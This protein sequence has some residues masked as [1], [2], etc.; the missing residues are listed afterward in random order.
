ME[1]T[2]NTS[3]QAIGL[4]MWHFTSVTTEDDDVSVRVEGA[5]VYL[6]CPWLLE[7]LLPQIAAE[8]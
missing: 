7:Q 1:Q 5:H 6:P 4:D 3:C 8:P 2:A